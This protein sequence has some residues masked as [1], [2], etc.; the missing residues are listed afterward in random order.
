M[1]PKFL[2]LI[3]FYCFLLAHAEINENNDVDLD[4]MVS[5][6]D[7]G[8]EKG[9]LDA[10]SHVTD[11]ISSKLVG[12]YENNMDQE[13]LVSA[14]ASDDSASS[15]SSSSLSSSIEPHSDLEDLKSST[16]VI[17][18]SETVDIIVVDSSKLVG[19]SEN[20]MDQEVLMSA[21]TSDD[22]AVPSTE[23]HSDLEDLKKSSTSPKTIET[24]ALNTP[25]NLDLSETKSD[26]VCRCSD[27]SVIQ[28]LSKCTESNN[29]RKVSLEDC[30]KNLTILSDDM[31]AVMDN[32]FLCQNSGTNS[33]DALTASAK[34]SEYYEEK[35]S[36]EIASLNLNIS[37]LSEEIKKLQMKNE[38]GKL[39]IDR[40][41]QE[42][43]RADRLYR[44]E[45][46][47]LLKE[48]RY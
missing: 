36:S 31:Q 18:E 2:L 23:P 38:L 46:S 37:I 35:Y 19:D 44:L 21:L 8:E 41:K 26:E 20:N 13:V 10:V 28:L 32:L 48:N 33:K 14:L 7:Y 47:R 4:L 17:K 40:L 11:A 12:D 25:L 42:A 30:S 1:L 22:S 16:P 39:A 24:E 6:I 43:E 3:A 34:E 27:G 15:S 29:L 45:V 9:D 5:D